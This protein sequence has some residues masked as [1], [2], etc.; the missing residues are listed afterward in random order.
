MNQMFDR[1][2]L[3]V[4]DANNSSPQDPGFWETFALK[5]GRRSMVARTFSEAELVQTDQMWNS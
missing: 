5:I 2:F 1:L 4:D 3:A